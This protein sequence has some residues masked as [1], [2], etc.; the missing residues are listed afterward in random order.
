MSVEDTV[1]VNSPI[2]RALAL[3]DGAVSAALAELFSDA[4]RLFGKAHGVLTLECQHPGLAVGMQVDSA[5]VS[6]DM[7]DRPR[8]ILTLADALDAVE[9]LDP[10]ASR[11]NERAHQF[12]RATVG[13]FWHKLDPYPSDPH[14]RIA[15][16]QASAL[17][18]DEA[19]LG[20]DLK[21]LAYNWRILALCE[22][23]LDVDVGI[24]RRS[25]AKQTGSG[26]SSVEMFIAMARYAGAITSGSDLTEAFRHGLRAICAYT[27]TKRLR[28]GDGVADQTSP[29]PAQLVQELLKEGLNDIVKTVPID[30]LIWQRFRSTWNSDFIAR[31]EASCTAAW[32]GAA[33]IAD[34]ISAALSGAVSGMPSTTLALAAN[35]AAMPPLGGNPRVRF[36]RDLLMVSH[37]ASSLARRV[38]EPVVVSTIAEGWSN[39]LSNESFA[40]RSLM[41]HAPAIAAALSGTKF[42]G[43]KAAARLL[44]AAAPTVRASLSESWQQ[45]LRQISGNG[46]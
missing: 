42:L 36:E 23:E 19:L 10:K 38:I 7:N 18:G 39:V 30:L 34:V 2:D 29:S 17:T 4:L 32:G 22:I 45:R 24:E 26:L 37:T 40:L 8:A 13:L 9:L 43:L 46:S 15:I 25:L 1:G 3:R 6:W 28:D 5:L 35:L 33:P 41:Q 27:T 11:Q 14:R 31:I 21:P 16:G 12:A 44:L 20:I